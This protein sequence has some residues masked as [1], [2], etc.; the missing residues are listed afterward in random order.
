LNVDDDIEYD[1]DG[2]DEYLDDNETPFGNN[3]GV[4]NSS[5]DLRFNPNNNNS[6]KRFNNN[7]SSNNNNTTNSSGEYV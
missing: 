1:D 5:N 4:L 7:N 6:N 2:Y 3:N